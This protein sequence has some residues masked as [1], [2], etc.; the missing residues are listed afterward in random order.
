MKDRSLDRGGTGRVP[1]RQRCTPTGG[2]PNQT[3]NLTP[4][5][6]TM[7]TKTNVKAGKKA[8]SPNG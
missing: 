3:T 7:K 6:K 4:R 5:G 2:H 8:M 1:T